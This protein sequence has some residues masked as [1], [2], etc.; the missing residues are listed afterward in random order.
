MEDISLEGII[1]KAKPIKSLNKT[2]LK[3]KTKCFCKIIASSIGTGFFCKIT[4]EDNLIPVLI[5]NYHV[6]DD[7]YIQ[8]NDK[9]KIYIND[10]YKI[11]KLNNRKI[12][13]SDKNK[14]DIMIIKLKDVDEIYDYLEI[15][16]NIFTN[17]S[18]NSYKNE[19]IYILQ[20]PDAEIASVSEGIGIEKMNEYKIKHLCNTKK[21]S[22]GGPIINKI[23]NKVMKLLLQ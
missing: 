7:N 21:G 16:K 14:Y 4:Y 12:Y 15:D 17:D 10:E 8:K 23:T 5:T 20:Y 3:S 13:S 2:N 11:I 6:I 1:P 19:P 18:E 22:S 9:L